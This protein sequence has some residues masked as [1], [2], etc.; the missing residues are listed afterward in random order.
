[1]PKEKS[2]FAYRTGGQNCAQSLYTG[3]QELLQVPQEVI[4]EAKKQGGGQAEGGR[5]GAL[6]AA[7]DLAD[8]AE[9]KKEL[10]AMFEEQAGSQQCREIRIKKQ[11][12]CDQC[13]ELAAAVLARREH[14]NR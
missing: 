11:M 14:P 1:M 5:C 8:H 2:L 6:H 10:Q 13:V 9:T 7:L 3:F 12:R 4:T